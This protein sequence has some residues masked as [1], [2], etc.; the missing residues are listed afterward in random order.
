M[1][2][3][4]ILIQEITRTAVNLYKTCFEEM[5]YDLGPTRNEVEY[6]NYLVD[7]PLEFVVG[8]GD[9]ETNF[10]LGGLTGGAAGDAGVSEGMVQF[11]C[12][13]ETGHKFGYKMPARDLNG[14][15][16]GD[17]N[18]H[19]TFGY[20]LLY[21]PTANKYMDQI[22]GSWSQQELEGLYKAD[23]A[24]RSRR[25]RSWASNNSVSLN[26]N[27]ID[28]I[29]SGCYNFGNGFLNKAVCKMIAKNP[30]DPNI[31]NVWA[32][33]SDIQGKKYPGLIKR[34]KAEANWYFGKF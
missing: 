27:Q 10:D 24:G 5:G 6:H 23:I 34:R 31:L 25:V 26:Q 9:G 4:E 12:N 1:D 32:H 8:G 30:N 3:S 20:G 33:M 16:L 22:K 11:I 18:G 13:M 29:V 15:D 2:D 28:A 7:D 17:A 19:R 21:H 14:Y